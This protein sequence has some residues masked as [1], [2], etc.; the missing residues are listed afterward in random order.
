MCLQV[1][2]V[3]GGT[4][5]YFGSCLFGSLVPLPGFYL[6]FFGWGRRSE[7]K[8]IVGGGSVGEGHCFL[9]HAPPE[10][11]LSFEPSKSDYEAF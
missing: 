3:L 8:L 10:N 7:L 6:G 11:V 4:D 2:I 9:G 5:T 1:G